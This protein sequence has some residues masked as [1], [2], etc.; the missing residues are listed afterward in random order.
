MSLFPKFPIDLLSNNH[1]GD[2]EIELRDRFGLV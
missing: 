2:Y 1:S